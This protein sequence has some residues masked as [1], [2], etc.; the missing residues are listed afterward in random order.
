MK[1]PFSLLAA[2]VLFAGLTLTQKAEAVGNCPL[3]WTP[4]MAFFQAGG[5]VSVLGRTLSYSVT[6]AN[7]AADGMYG[8]SN[9]DYIIITPP[10]CGGYTWGSV[11][12][13]Y[14]NAQGGL[15][16]DPPEPQNVGSLVNLTL[17]VSISCACPNSGSYFN[18]IWIKANY[19]KSGGGGTGA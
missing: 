9:G 11:T 6:R 12:F 5:T 1:K 16:Q 10:N 18:L 7:A 17:Q 14:C 8:L 4:D 19:C 2:L 3:Y 13:A 15:T